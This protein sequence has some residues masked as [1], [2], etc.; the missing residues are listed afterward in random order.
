MLSL[1]YT[2]PTEEPV[3]KYVRNYRR[4]DLP[5]LE[6]ELA[7]LNWTSV[8][9]SADIDSKVEHFNCL[10]SDLLERFVPLKLVTLCKV[11][12]LT[13]NLSCSC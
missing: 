3:V 7:Q 2:K 11:L 8:F 1:G 4:I 12:L 5:A 6:A 10:L 13:V 9:L